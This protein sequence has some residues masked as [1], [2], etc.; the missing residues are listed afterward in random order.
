MF[1]LLWN[2]YMQDV[3]PALL[4][5]NK[6]NQMTMFIY[7]CCSIKSLNKRQQLPLTFMVFGKDPKCAKLLKIN[8]AGPPYAEK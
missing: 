5:R 2:K 3:A 7:S 1:D 8:I 6:G 4:A